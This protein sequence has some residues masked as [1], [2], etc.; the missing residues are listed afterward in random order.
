MKIAVIGAGVAGLTSSYI[1]SQKHE[2]SLFE[3]NDYL[4]GHTN[5]IEVPVDT[6][7]VSV[8][9]GFIVFNELNYPY[10]CSFLN[11]LGVSSQTSNMSFAFYDD[12]TPFYYSS[13]GLK[14]LFSQ[15]KNIVNPKFYGLIFEINR[16]NKAALSFLKDPRGS[17]KSMKD[18]IIQERFSDY[19]VSTY[20]LPMGA[21]IW[22]C[23][24]TD[25]L[26]FPAM[27]F[28]QF[29]NNHRMLTLGNR[30]T[31]RTVS[32]GS[33]QYV[34]RFESVFKGDIYKSCPIKTIHRNS[35]GVELRTMDQKTLLFDC[36]VMATHSDQ[37]LSLLKSP[38]SEETSLFSQWS[39]SH[40]KVV[41]HTD[42]SM[43]PPTRSAWASWNYNFNSKNSSQVSVTYHMNRLQNLSCSTDF[44][45]TLNPIQEINPAAVIKEIHY[46]HPI[47][48]FESISTQDGIRT[49]SGQNNTYFCGSYLGYGFHEDAVKSA[50]DVAAQFGLKL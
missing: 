8:D 45:V 29:W 27:S 32:G 3:S 14:G 28:I 48:S 13:I 2:V 20:L 23:S 5:T 41:L 50:V 34:K 44:F 40:N 6:K 15:K 46:T 4:G 1:L 36:V 9:T 31:W 10:F 11:R 24:Y 16:F 39:Y 33:Y 18:F 35:D 38:T 22:S 43:M 19:F 42:S 17:E 49:L 30:P 21:A 12:S 25:I 7:M 37:V 47:Y 26:N